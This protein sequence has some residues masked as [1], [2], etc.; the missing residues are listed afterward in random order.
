MDGKFYPVQS[1]SDVVSWGL[2][3][4]IKPHLLARIWHVY[5][6]ARS[7]LVAET[8]QAALCPTFVTRRCGRFGGALT[9]L[10]NHGETTRTTHCVTLPETD[11]ET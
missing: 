2:H 10:K 6:P 9:V 4:Q 7:P 5:D 11:E 8:C 3:L 1:L